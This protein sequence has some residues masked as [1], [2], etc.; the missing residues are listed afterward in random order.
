MVTDY[1]ETKVMYLNAYIFKGLNKRHP[2]YICV[3]RV[4]AE[5][6]RSNFPNRIVKLL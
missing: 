5:M 2:I 3:A 4:H 6:C 1:S